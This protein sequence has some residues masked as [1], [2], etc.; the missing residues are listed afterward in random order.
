M[1]PFAR[2]EVHIDA[3]NTTVDD[4]VALIRQRREWNK[5]TG[6]RVLLSGMQMEQNAGRK[7]SSYLGSAR[8]AYWI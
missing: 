5:D 8:Y 6:V 3:E 2:E 4:L 7:L 1:R